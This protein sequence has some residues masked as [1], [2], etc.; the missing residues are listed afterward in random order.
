MRLKLYKEWTWAQRYDMAEFPNAAVLS[1]CTFYK[2]KIIFSWFS[3]ENGANAVRTHAQ[4]FTKQWRIFSRKCKPL[5]KIIKSLNMKYM[6]NLFSFIRSTACFV[7]FFGRIW[8]LSPF[9]FHLYTH[10]PLNYKADFIISISNEL[11][12]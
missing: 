6:Y 8:I 5:D 7:C 3:N 12:P 4:T 2:C 9:D 11:K 10:L 1:S